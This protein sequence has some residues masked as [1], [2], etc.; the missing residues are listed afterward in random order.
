MNHAQDSTTVSNRVSRQVRLARFLHF[1]PPSLLFP[2]CLMV[3]AL[4]GAGTLAAQVAPPTN[5]VGF[6]LNGT[7]SDPSTNGGMAI[8]GLMNFN[9][10]GVVSGPYDLEIGSGG[11]QTQQSVSGSFT[12]AYSFA[13]NGTGT[14]TLAFDSGLTLNLDVLIDGHSRGMELVVTSCSG[15]NC[16]LTGTVISG[17]GE[18]EFDGR[19]HTFAAHPLNGSYGVHS[20]KSS[21]TPA[22]SLGVWTFDHKGNATLVVTFVSTNGVVQTGTLTGTYSAHSNGTGTITI[23]PTGAQSGQTHMFVI[24]D[25]GFIVLQT[26]RAGDGVLY[27]IG[28]VQ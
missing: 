2:V 1:Q 3:L 10:A 11:T 24:T 7:F 26:N 14:M 16:D 20:T 15:T 9:G 8:L 27:G 18:L 22:T 28:S 23:P 17:V 4:A 25:R 12:G 21:P 19:P 13:S 5:P 6:V